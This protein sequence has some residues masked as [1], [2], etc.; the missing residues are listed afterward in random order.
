[1]RKAR[2]EK[3][4]TIAL[5]MDQFEKI[6]QITD[7]DQISLAEWIRDALAVVLNNI[8]REEEQMNDK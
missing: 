7:E 2:F 6:K 3:Q 4:L 5:P 8:K 1:M